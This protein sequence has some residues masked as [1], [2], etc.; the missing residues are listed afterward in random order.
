[1]PHP[2]TLWRVAAVLVL[3]GVGPAQASAQRNGSFPLGQDPSPGLPDLSVERS[4]RL[5][6]GSGLYPRGGTILGLGT[7]G[8]LTPVKVLMPGLSPSALPMEF[9]A[10]IGPALLYDGKKVLHRS[11]KR[12]P[13]NLVAVTGVDLPISPRLDLRVDAENY[14]DGTKLCRDRDAW[15]DLMLSTRV[16]LAIG[17][18]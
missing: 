14:I 18:R 9:H 3:S 13:A 12:S 4:D 7:V 1:M 6:E 10:G 16:G 5:T 15:N 8:G 17:G 2:T 11:Q